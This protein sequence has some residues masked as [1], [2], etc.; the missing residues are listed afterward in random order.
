MI[1]LIV[2]PFSACCYLIV[3]SAGM[4]GRDGIEVKAS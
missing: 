4:A 3:Q 2:L 1:F